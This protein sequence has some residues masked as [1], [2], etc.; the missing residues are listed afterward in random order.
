MEHLRLG[1][2][3]ANFSQEKLLD[4]LFVKKPAVADDLLKV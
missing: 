3:L 2:E 4:G 1:T